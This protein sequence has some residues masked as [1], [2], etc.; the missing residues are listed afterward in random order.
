MNIFVGENNSGKS[1][2]LRSFSERLPDIRHR[3]S[4]EW[5]A[6]YLPLPVHTAAVDYAGSDLE[7]VLRRYAQNGV[8]WL[9][10]GPFTNPEVVK[11]HASKEM[12]KPSSSAII[13]RRNGGFEP[14]ERAASDELVNAYTLSFVQGSWVV[15]NIGRQQVTDGIPS[16]LTTV[17]SENVFVFSAL[18]ASPGKM[19]YGAPGRLDQNASNLAVQLNGLQGDRP[20]VLQ[21]S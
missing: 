15:Q 18:R 7:W 6:E 17:W 3:S 11:A 8:G 4:Q 1:A 21:S 9:F 19:G 16:L 14:F 5:R 13:E 12:A 20:E 10:A 2:V